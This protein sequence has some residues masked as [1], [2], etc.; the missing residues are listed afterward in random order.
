MYGQQKTE[1]STQAVSSA[2]PRAAADAA[3]AATTAAAAEETWTFPSPQRFYNAMARKGWAPQEK[4][5]SHV[6]SV[7][8]TVNEM[9]W[10]MVMEYEALHSGDC[11]APKLRSF[12]GRPKDFSPK[13]RLRN[14]FLGSVL[15]FDR[16][17]W[18]IDR[19]GTDVKY[20]I[21]FY[22]G[23]APDAATAAA[24]PISASMYL[25]VRPALTAAGAIDRLRM[26]ARRVTQAWSAPVA[27]PGA[28]DVGAAKKV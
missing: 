21:D 18:V 25:D 9:T 20:V 12:R 17:D 3:A 11:A 2:I 1:L 13:A 26:Q 10:R 23:R 15:P 24:T 5:M 19:C 4:D 6:V 28:A 7:H 14:I 27:R 8:N 16:H 22:T